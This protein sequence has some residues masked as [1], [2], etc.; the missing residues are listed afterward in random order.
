MAGAQHIAGTIAQ[1]DISASSVLSPLR[2]QH[3]ATARQR[4]LLARGFRGFRNFDGANHNFRAIPPS[5]PPPATSATSR[6]T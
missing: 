2:R 1:A 3:V 5:Q 6:S 4:D